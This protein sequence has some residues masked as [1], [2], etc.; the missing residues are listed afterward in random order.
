M[1]IL[2]F[3]NVGAIGY[4][5]K[6]LVLEVSSLRIGGVRAHG[7]QVSVK[8]Y[9]KGSYENLCKSLIDS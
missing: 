6:F 4:Y 8:L 1:E 5:K 2:W 9:F 7:R 3:N